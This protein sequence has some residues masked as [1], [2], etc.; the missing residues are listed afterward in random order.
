MPL[1]TSSLS[2]PS[3]RLKAVAWRL[4]RAAA[5]ALVLGLGFPVLAQTDAISPAGLFGVQGQARVVIDPTGQQTPAE[6]E[7][8]FARGEG[9]V[10]SADRI[11]PMGGPAAVW[12]ELVLPAVGVPTP[13]VLAVP[14]PSMDRV[15]LYRPLAGA[16]WSAQRSGDSTAVAKWPLRHLHPAF[17]FV[18]QP[19]EARASYLRVQHSNQI[20]VR[21]TLSSAREF[22]E[23]SKRWHLLLGAYSGLVALVIM[24]CV[25][26]A[27]SWRDPIHFYFAV[28][29]LVVAFGQ[30]SITGLAGEY[31]WP[32]NPW[33]NDAAPRV[34]PAA[35]VALGHVL[36]RQLVLARG[37]RWAARLMLGM[38]A[39]GGV[40]AMGFL[41][42]GRD[43]FF[44]I[45]GPYYL[46]S[47][48][49]YLGA[50]LWYAWRIPRVGLWVLGGVL[51]LIAGAL[52]PLLRDLQLVPMSFWTQYGAQLGAGLQIPLL[53]IALYIRS[54]ASRDNQS[55]V[56]AMSK[57]DP[58]TGVPNHGVMVQ[59]LQHLLQHQQKDPVAGVVLRV[60]IG[61]IQE[62]RAEYGL[63][64]A[65]MA[66]VHAGACITQVVR[67]GDTV[68]RHRDGDFIL[69][70]QGRLTRDQLSSIGQRLIA[71]GLA[72]SVVLPQ[73]AVLQLK[74]AIAESPF[75]SRDVELLLQSL[76]VVVAELAARPGK[77]LRFV[78]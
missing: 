19:G 56:G 12:Y 13:L 22:Q 59:R 53:L 2:V 76:E 10:A 62:L 43:P 36:M 37:T 9:A 38:A 23:A 3:L 24:I 54:R 35:A 26:N 5:A 42:I 29:A 68:A 39:T 41:F 66:L 33:W 28:Y 48:V 51:A 8:R 25:V 73:G 78:A 16:D 70:L 55:R 60:R 40:L 52:F 65:Q 77:A 44:A 64:V 58:L 7:Q 57:V 49:T 32:H 30:L 1:F 20:S 71:R 63:Q 50:A 46:A 14:H 74:V 75:Q 27:Y 72:P 34:L 17:E 18:L 31:L 15:E 61:N 21:W 11:M 47:F 45:T 6:I 69:I 4:A 67:E